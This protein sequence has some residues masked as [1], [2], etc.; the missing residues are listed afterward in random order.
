MKK[1]IKAL[2]LSLL[3]SICFFVSYF[4]HEGTLNLIL[5]CVWLC[6]AIIIGLKK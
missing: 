4:V 6:I 3:A 1:N 2:C 5:A